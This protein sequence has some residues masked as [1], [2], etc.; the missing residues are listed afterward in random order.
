MHKEQGNLM[1]D[2]ILKQIRL[3][4]AFLAVCCMPIILAG[5]E[6]NVPRQEFPE[7]TYSHISPLE[8]NVGVLDI[9][10]DYQPPLKAPNV[11]HL[12]PVSPETALRRW[13]DDRLA[14]HGQDGVA[15]F[16]IID[17]SVRETALKMKTGLMGVF[18]KEQSER[19]EA[20]IETMLEILDSQGVRKAYATARV[21]N[22]LT[23]REDATVNEREQAWF[24]L[25]ETLMKDFNREM[26]SNIRKHLVNWI[27]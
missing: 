14:N 21:G 24:N 25:T 26:E 11:E 17:A 3:L 10:V 23:V 9:V 22:T 6:A 1:K 19:Y 4:P 27:K 12:F 18:T 2:A 16:I 15:R 7:I 13:A 20:N 8:L 5:C